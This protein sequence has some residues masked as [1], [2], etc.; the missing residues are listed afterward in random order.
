MILT[1]G[2]APVLF[3]QADKAL[4]ITVLPDLYQR[5]QASPYQVEPAFLWRRLGISLTPEGKVLYD[6]EAPWAP[7]RRAIVQPGPVAQ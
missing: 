5:F 6:D 3:R 4:G 7:V 1:A 2:D